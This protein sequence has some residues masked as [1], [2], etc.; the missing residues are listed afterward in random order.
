MSVGR[1]GGDSPAGPAGRRQRI[2]LYGGSFDPIHLGHVLPIEEARR[3]LALDRVVY[4]PTATP[5]HKLDREMAPAHH[6]LAMVRLALRNRPGIEISTFEMGEMGDAGD[7]QAEPSYTVRTLEHFQ[8]A[9][10]QLF[11][12]LGADSFVGLHRWRRFAELPELAE[13]VVL[14]RPGF[15]LD[16]RALDPILLRAIERGRVHVVANAPRAV[17]STELRARLAAGEDPPAGWIEEPVLNYIDAHGLY[18]RTA[19]LDTD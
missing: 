18:G 14:A 9:D 11:L 19:A 17:S 10:R 12:L 15:A 6:R 1:G 8:A 2:G 7:G 13:L 16:P 5:P 4:L 3:A